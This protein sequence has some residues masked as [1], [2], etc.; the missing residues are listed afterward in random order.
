MHCIYVCILHNILILFPLLKY[1]LRS[2]LALIINLNK[3]RTV[4]V[5]S[6]LYTKAPWPS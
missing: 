4:V 2:H 1:D 6:G 5:I 3:K